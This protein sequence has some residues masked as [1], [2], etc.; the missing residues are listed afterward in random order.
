VNRRLV[1]VQ[2][3]Q[4]LV[5]S[6]AHFIADMFGNML[7]VILPALRAEFT[8]TLTVGGLVVSACVLTS[9]L[10]QMLTGHTRANKSIPVLLYIGL[11]TGGAI[12]FISL[13][14]RTSLGIG[15]MVLMAAVS[16]V[17]IAL[18][19]PEGLRAMHRLD[20]IP[21]GLS[22]AI[23]M[24]GGFVGYSAGGAL[25]AE[26]VH[27][28]GLGGLRWIALGPVVAI[29]LVMLARVRLAVESETPAQQPHSA[30][31]IKRL[32]FWPLMAVAI[33]AGISTTILCMLMPTRLEELG[34]ALTWGGYSS[35]VYGIG[36]A[37][38]SF[39]LA[40]LAY[41]TD[42]MKLVVATL[43][44][45]PFILATYLLAIAHRAAIVLLFGQGF[46][47][48]GS[49]I[50]LITLA[51]YATGPNLGRRMGFI[52]GGTWGV[53]VMVFMA[54]TP[55]ADRFGTQPLLYSAVGGYFVSACMALWL[56][57][58]AA[59]KASA[60]APTA[61]EGIRDPVSRTPSTV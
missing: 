17:G 18:V 4:L 6:A 24:M 58:H 60:A 14:P 44:A 19:H 22:T 25:S 59:Q 31:S 48:M 27:R 38:G 46:C 39:T 16:G 29:V 26:F 8:M 61:L 21:A 53:A 30:G 47:A 10:V 32:P 23:F 35:T 37:V 36:A 56:M 9:N 28:W 3:M 20:A 51:R 12:C 15:I 34:F 43:L 33:P 45:A 1:A 42:E 49:Y 41:R 5:L 40:Y 11:A 2:W 50:L 54:L 52:I 55:V 7:P 57:K 13:L